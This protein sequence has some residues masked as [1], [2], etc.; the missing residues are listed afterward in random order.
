MALKKL[1]TYFFFAPKNETITDFLENTEVE[2]RMTDGPKWNKPIAMAS[3]HP[4]V[5]FK[6]NEAQE[7]CRPIETL[8]H[9]EDAQQQ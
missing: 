3:A 9:A 2:F 7:H 6:P 1:R 8:V 5:H 4:F